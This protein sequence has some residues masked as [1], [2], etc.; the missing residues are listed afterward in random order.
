MVVDQQ[1]RWRLEV[2][3]ERRAQIGS[4]GCGGGDWWLGFDLG[5]DRQGVAMGYGE[6]GFSAMG[7]KEE[8]QESYGD[9]AMG[10]REE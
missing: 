2:K 5:S 10:L 1:W 7:L 9:L 6:D 3:V 4:G 8:E